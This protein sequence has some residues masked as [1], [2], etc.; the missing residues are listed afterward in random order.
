METLV[1]ST[2]D[3][4]TKALD[5]L[6]QGLYP[7][8]E[9]KLKA[10]Y[11][12]DWGDAARRS[13][14]DDRSRRNS[15]EA[16]RWDAHN[17]LTIM[18]DQW[19]SV[20]RND[21]KQSDRSLVSE[22]REFRNRWAHQSEFDFDDTYRILDSVHRILCA[23][24][25]NEAATIA[26]HKEEYLRDHFSE[27]INAAAAKT[28]FRRESRLLITLSVVCCLALVGQF[29]QTFGTNGV[30]MSFIVTIAFGLLIYRRLTKAPPKV[31]ARE[32]KRCGKIIYDEVCPYCKPIM[33]TAE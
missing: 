24:N 12:D 25:A 30:V 18:W 33:A 21:L 23:I 15:N 3:R 31:G 20:F 4:V 9:T 27:E 11:H 22:L 8:V 13:F 16:I 32:C 14:R 29:L 17:L 28:E 7:Y 19:N 26:N 2:R 1:Q 10:I 5:L 6:A